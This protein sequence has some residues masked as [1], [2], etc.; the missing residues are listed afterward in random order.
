MYREELNLFTKN[1]KKTGDFDIKI[2]NIQPGYWNGICYWKMCNVD[3][4][5]LVKR[6]NGVYITAKSGKNQNVWRKRKSQVLRS[7]RSGHY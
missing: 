3:N 4:E 1:M 5:K 2:K 7:N 6:N